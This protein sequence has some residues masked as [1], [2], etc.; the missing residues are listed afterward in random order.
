MI[1]YICKAFLL[2]DTI[3]SNHEKLEFTNKAVVKE[4]AVWPIMKVTK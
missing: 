4:H 2:N 1:E 3:V